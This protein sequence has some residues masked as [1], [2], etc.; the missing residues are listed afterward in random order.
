[1]EAGYCDQS[2]LT[3]EFR[4]LHVTPAEYRRLAG[5]ASGSTR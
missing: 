2:H 3:R 4:R 5:R 1:M